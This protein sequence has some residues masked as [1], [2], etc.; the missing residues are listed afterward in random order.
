MPDLQEA[1]LSVFRNPLIDAV[2]STSSWYA[3]VADM[4]NSKLHYVSQNIERVTG[5]SAAQTIEGFPALL[6]SRMEPQ[7]L[8]QI[9]NEVPRCLSLYKSQPAENRHHFYVNLLYKIYTQD[10]RLIW[11]HEQI[12]PLLANENGEVILIMTIGR[13]ATLHRDMAAGALV[14]PVTEP[15]PSYEH[16][17]FRGLNP[18]CNLFSAR[19][20]DVLRLLA[21]GQKR[22]NIAKQLGISEHTVDSHRKSLLRKSGS[23]TLGDLINFCIDT[24]ILVPSYREQPSIAAEG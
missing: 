18:G 24:S 13:E 1:L 20:M 6:Y 11:I 9:V 22:V 19:E 7:H 5:Y 21:S 17:L 23:N 15:E 8:K 16:M 14:E 10:N 12:I 3:A 4:A 2:I